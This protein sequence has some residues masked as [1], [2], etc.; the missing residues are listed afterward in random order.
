M[1]F[2]S[3]LIVCTG[4]ICR[5]PIGEALLKARL[6]N[7]AIESAGLGALVD[8]GVDPSAQALAEGEGLSVAHHK[9]R[10]ITEDMILRAD[11]IL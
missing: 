9:A 7:M 10:Q 2:S 6:P 4:N 3:V 11:L 1:K 8:R 5:S